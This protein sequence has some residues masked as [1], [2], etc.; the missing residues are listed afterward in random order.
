MK[1]NKFN[2]RII[3]GILAV[4]VFGARIVVSFQQREN[5]EEQMRIMEELSRKQLEEGWGQTNTDEALKEALD[6]NLDET[7]KSLD[8][9]KSDLK[10]IGK[11]LDSLQ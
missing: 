1:E 2:W 9:T 6:L 10:A 3:V 7:L 5:Q 4:L 8:S 11:R